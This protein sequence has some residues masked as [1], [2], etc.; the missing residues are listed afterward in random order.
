MAESFP[1]LNPQGVKRTD[2]TSSVQ[3]IICEGAMTLEKKLFEDLAQSMREAQA[4][5]R[6]ATPA[7]RRFEFPQ[8]D[9]KAVREKAGLSPDEFARMMRVSTKTLQNWEHH[10]RKP[11]GP[12]A[13]LLKIM[14]AAPDLALKALYVGH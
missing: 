7:S 10:R 4:I 8:A 11:S 6:G 13:A 3:R 1:R 14:S 5:S 12:A 9:A 2:L